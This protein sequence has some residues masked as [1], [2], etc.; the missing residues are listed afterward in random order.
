MLKE[1]FPGYESLLDLFLGKIEF[2][3]IPLTHI[4]PIAKSC[5]GR[6]RDSKDTPIYVAITLVKPDYVVAGDKALRQ[7]LKRSYMITRI[8][9]VCSTKEFLYDR[10]R[11]GIA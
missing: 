9:K 8:T 7:A 6:V 4:L 5:R 2:E 10:K 1:K 11:R 3:L